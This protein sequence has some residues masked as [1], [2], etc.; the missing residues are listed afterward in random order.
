MKDV[1]GSKN[2]KFLGLPFY[3]KSK[4]YPFDRSGRPMLLTAQLNSEEI[5]TL[6]DFPSDGILQLFLSATNWVDREC[7]IV[8]HN[9]DEMEEESMDDFSFISP[10]DYEKMPMSKVHGLTFEK[11]VE[12]GGLNDCQFDFHFG[13]INWYEF[14][15]KLIGQELSEFFAF[16]EVGG[17]KLGGYAEFSQADDPRDYKGRNKDDV[18]LLQMDTEKDIVFENGG[19][20]H[21]FIDKASLKNKE[22]QNAYFTWDC[23]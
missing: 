17:H 15:S 5:P 1:T 21:V 12:N 18:Q 7:T 13:C 4:E 6:L 3:P 22:F 14:T 9:K 2:S 20:G 8:Y 23:N 10:M 19:I 11:S 16:F